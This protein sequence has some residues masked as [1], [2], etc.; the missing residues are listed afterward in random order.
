[1]HRLSKKI[2]DAGFESHL[3]SAH[4]FLWKTFFSLF[5]IQLCRE[6]VV[7]KNFILVTRH[8]FIR[9]GKY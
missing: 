3:F 6:F 8:I 2:T 4:F 5:V 9:I 7:S 1:M